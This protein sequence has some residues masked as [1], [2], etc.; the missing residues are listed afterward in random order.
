LPTRPFTVSLAERPQ[1]MTFEMVRVTNGVPTTQPLTVVDDCGP[2]LTFIGSGPNS[3]PG[4][5]TLS[6]E[7][8]D[9][10]PQTG[11]PAAPDPQ[12]SPSRHR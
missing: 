7:S 5:S 10:F 11:T 3:W 1:R 2:W 8:A 4:T 6:D 12:P 9:P